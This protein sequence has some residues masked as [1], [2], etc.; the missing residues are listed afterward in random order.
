M[1][2][3]EA[4]LPVADTV[5]AEKFYREI[6]GLTFAYRDPARDIVF[7]WVDAKEKGMLGLWG[8]RTQYGPDAQHAPSHHLAFAVEFD[9]LLGAIER[10]EAHGVE[11][12]GFGG[13]KAREPTVIGWMPS[14]QTYFQD[15][16]GHSLEFISILRQEPRPGFI[17]SYAEWRRVCA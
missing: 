2:L 9:Q 3:Y 8:P 16:D 14:A 15:L 7:L 4:H 10:L 5:A 1:H 11:T 17:G 12:F 6:V 13:E